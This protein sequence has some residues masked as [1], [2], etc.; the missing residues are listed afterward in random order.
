MEFSIDAPEEKVE[1]LQERMQND[2]DFLEL[3]ATSPQ[4]A[5]AEYG[6]EMDDDTAEAIR[7]HFEDIL[8]A[9]PGPSPILM[10]V[11]TTSSSRQSQ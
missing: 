5:L 9:A 6:I 8:G 10:A 2:R 4:K 1:E 7:K 3:L 11:S